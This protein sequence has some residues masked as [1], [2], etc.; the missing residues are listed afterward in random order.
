MITPSVAAPGQ[1]SGQGPTTES[2]HPFR[3]DEMAV[4][5]GKS[6]VVV[7]DEGITQMQLQSILARAGLR[8]LGRARN[9]EE[10]VRVVLQ[11]RPDVV[12]MDINMP[13]EFDG[14]EAARRILAEFDTCIVM[15]TAYDDFRQ[16][17]EQSGTCGYI[18]KP[19]NS[20]ML[21]TALEDAWREFY[22]H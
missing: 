8:V 18:L 19:V 4:L 13:G 14:L 7:E 15:I 12:L 6:A 10:G 16:E 5:K 22:R 21:M 20:A 17:A 3:T 11:E 9:G 1:Q 2:H